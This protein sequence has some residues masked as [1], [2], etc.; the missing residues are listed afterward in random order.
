VITPTFKTFEVVWAVFSQKSH[1]PVASC[2]FYR[3]AASCQ[4]VATGLLVLPGGN[5][6]AGTGL[7]QADLLKQPA[8]NL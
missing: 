5:R 6:L 2:L 3:L 1:M 8:T 7:S 4:Q